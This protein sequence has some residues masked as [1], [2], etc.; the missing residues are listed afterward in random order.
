MIVA[1]GNGASSTLETA[2]RLIAITD[3][4]RDGIDGL[5]ARAAAAVRGG[6]TMV[7]VRL[8][9]E[10]ARTLVEVTRRLVRDVHVPVLVNDRV[11]VAIAAGAAGVHVGEDD[12]PVSAV[13]ALTPA[14]F[15]VG[16]SFGADAE[17][18]NASGADYVG[19]GP[20][21]ATRS[22]N[23]A[24]DAIGVDGFSRLRAKVSLPAVGI[25]GVTASNARALIASGAAGVAVIASVFGAGDPEVAARNLLTAMRS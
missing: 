11:D 16:A 12:L 13:R 14:G 23:D 25:G 7:Q 2:L 18:E 24:G 17:L 5:A 9:D 15:I 3:D 8:K 6:A 22:K 19:I 20:V 10:D 21:Y 4:L 1:P